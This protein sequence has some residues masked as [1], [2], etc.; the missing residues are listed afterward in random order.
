MPR[1]NS[2]DCAAKDGNPFGPYW[3]NFGVDF[4]NSEFYAPLSFDPNFEK[5][6]LEWTTRFPAEKFPVLAFTGAPGAF[7][8]IEANVPL[9]KYVKWSDKIDSK[10]D[11]FINQFKNDPK[12]KFIGIHLR[13]GIDFV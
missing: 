9:H 7:P 12:E 6:R 2:N 11:S 3:D 5:H 10:A 1:G 8:V 13:N 4:D